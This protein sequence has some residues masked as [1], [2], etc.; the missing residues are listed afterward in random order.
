MFKRTRNTP[1]DS[2]VIDD[3]MIEIPT[4]PPSMTLFGIRNSSR[5]MAAINA[6]MKIIRY[7]LT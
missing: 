1:R 2:P 3:I 4:M 5:P 7:F 6:P